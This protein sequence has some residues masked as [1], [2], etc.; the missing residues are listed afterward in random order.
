MAGITA[1]VTGSTGFVG[2]HLCKGLLEQGL[3]VRAFHRPSSTRQLLEGL[4]V[5]HAQGDLT[6]PETLEA[7]LDGI[8]VI[9]H[10]AAWMGGHDQAGR[11]Y[12]VTVEGTR[13]LLVAARKAGVSRFVHTSS[14]AAL[15]VPRINAGLP[16]MIDENHTWNF[17]PDYYPYGYAKYLAELEVQRA[18]ALG[19]DAVIV[20]PTLVFGP[21]DVYRQASSII[22]QVARRRVSV[23]TDGGVNCIHINDVVSGHIAAYREGQTGNRYIFGCENLTFNQLLQII[24]EVTGVPAPGLVLPA[25]LPR[26]VSLPAS[27]LQSFLNLPIPPDML[28]LTGHYFFYNTHKAQ[29]ELGFTPQYTVRQAVEDS[30]L[31]FKQPR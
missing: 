4:D 6:Q 31:W 20:N 12:A 29:S 27:V 3:R 7:A 9:F 26:T 1:L 17:R 5:E 11:Q 10:A 19:L 15:G 16:V 13:N 2:S 18:V 28:R 22:T 25:W 14:V 24:A 21:G 30:Y 8:D 23:V